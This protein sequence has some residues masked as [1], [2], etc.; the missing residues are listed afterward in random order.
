[1]HFSNRKERIA[2]MVG[3]GIVVA[4]GLFATIAHYNGDRTSTNS[5]YETTLEK[6]RILAQMRIDLLQSVEM[7][8]N[9]VM[10]L[11]DQESMDFANQSRTASAAVEQN[12]HLLRSL[13]ETVPSQDEQ[14]LLAE[15]TTC[16]TELG[17]LDQV[18]LQLAVENTNLK[19]AAL[20]RGRGSEALRGFELALDRLLPAFAGTEHESRATGL[21]FRAHIAGLKLYNLHSAHIAEAADATMDRIEAQMK[22]EDS[23]VADSLGALSSLAGTDQSDIVKQAQAAFAEFEAVTAEVVRLSRQ[24]S[25]VKSLELSFGKKRSMAAQCGS[26]LAAFQ[27]TVHNKTYKATK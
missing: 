11:T 23:T 12:L 4:I 17:K 18:I 24:N 2:F 16:W 6:K 7:E 27:E 21:I 8:K 14:E 26:V 1:M 19:A 10:A 3:I 13:V 20:S 5:P 22:E 15:F 9:A 25:N